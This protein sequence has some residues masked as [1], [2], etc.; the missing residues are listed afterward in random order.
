[1]IVYRISTKK[2]I[3]DLSGTGSKLH[4][5]RWN[6]KGFALLYTSEHKSLAALELLVHLDRNSIPEDLEIVS[7]EISDKHI[8][9]FS[10]ST[11]NGI[12]RDKNSL[13]RFKEEGKNWIETGSSLG[14]KVPSILISGESNILINPSHES[15]KEIKIL[16]IDPFNYDERLFG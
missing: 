13:S 8:L 5:G 6:P 15:F 9:K 4:G 10:D 12:I 3:R 11:Y 16:D 2:Y 7:I 1:M 14:L